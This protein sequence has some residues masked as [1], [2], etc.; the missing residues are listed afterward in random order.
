MGF[1]SSEFLA[2]T[3]NLF[4]ICL[5]RQAVEKDGNII[6]QAIKCIPKLISE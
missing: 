6:I 2:M 3:E 5:E 1:T 4:N